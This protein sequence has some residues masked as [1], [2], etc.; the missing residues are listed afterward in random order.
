MVSCHRCEQD[1][2]RRKIFCSVCGLIVNR[3]EFRV[4]VMESRAKDGSVFTEKISQVHVNDI[5]GRRVV[6]TEAQKEMAHKESQQRKKE[7]KAKDRII[8]NVP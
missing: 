8:V 5:R 3:P 7:L 2:E 1:R 6:K 4:K